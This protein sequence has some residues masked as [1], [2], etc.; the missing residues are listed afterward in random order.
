MMKKT[1]A[2]L[3]AAAAIA[4]V[5]IAVPSDA[6]AQRCRGACVGGAVAAGVVGGALLGAAIANPYG[7]APAPV[8]VAPAPV[9]AEPVCRV[10]R[11]RF[12][13]GYAWRVRTVEVC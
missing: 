5:T 13:D 9:Y 11:E 3:A 6:N 1:L 4:L 7:V 2:A 10:R 8:Y 12:W